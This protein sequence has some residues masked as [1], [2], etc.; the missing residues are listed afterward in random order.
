[1]SFYARDPSMML[2]ETLVVCPIGC[3]S[4]SGY[5]GFT[6]PHPGVLVHHIVFKVDVSSL[7]YL[8]YP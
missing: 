1:M 3:S 5:V 6:I 8:K 4:E 2:R 7:Y